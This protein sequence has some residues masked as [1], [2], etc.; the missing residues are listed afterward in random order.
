MILAGLLIVLLILAVLPSCSDAKDISTSLA[1]PTTL[2]SVPPPLDEKNRPVDG[3]EDRT[4]EEY[5]VYSIVVIWVHRQYRAGLAFRILDQTQ[6]YELSDSQY[7]RE[8][9]AFVPQAT[10]N[11]YKRVNTEPFQ[12]NDDPDLVQKYGLVHKESLDQIFGSD[13]DGWDNFY[14]KY[15]DTFGYIS[16]SGVGF[17][18]EIDRAL[19]YTGSHCGYTCG[20]GYLYY[21]VKDLGIWRIDKRIPLWIS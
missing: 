20:A 13:T 5:A 1:D 18:S 4:T 10:L 6:P 12:L 11:N 2:S 9:L 16:L 17:N 19:V 3:Q 7:L 21:L 15:P 14:E 8:Q